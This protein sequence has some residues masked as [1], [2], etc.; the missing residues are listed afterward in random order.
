MGQSSAIEFTS[1]DRGVAGAALPEAQCRMT[2]KVFSSSD[3]FDRSGGK[4]AWIISKMLKYMMNLCFRR[5]EGRAE[6]GDY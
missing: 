1:I 6:P 4:D 5:S 3:T 2:A